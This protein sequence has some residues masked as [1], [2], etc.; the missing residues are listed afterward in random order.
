MAKKLFLSSLFL[1]LTTPYSAKPLDFKTKKITAIK[2]E[3]L[4]LAAA[5]EHNDDLLDLLCKNLEAT[6]YLDEKY[7][8]IIIVCIGGTVCLIHILLCCLGCSLGIGMY[9]H[10]GIREEEYFES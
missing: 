3:I 4:A 7:I 10:K 9:C 2:H 6:A 1:L 8:P 5:L